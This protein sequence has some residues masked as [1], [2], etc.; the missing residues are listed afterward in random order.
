V[1]ITGHKSL[2]EV[3]R[4]TRAAQQKRLAKVAITKLGEGGS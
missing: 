1:S 3:E 2:S 4:Y